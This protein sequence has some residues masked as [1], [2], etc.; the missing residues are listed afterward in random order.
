M[1]EGWFSAADLAVGARGKHVMAKAAVGVCAV[2]RH[3]DSSRP[4]EFDRDL[5]LLQALGVYVC[6]VADYCSR[7]IEAAHIHRY[8]AVP[9]RVRIDQVERNTQLVVAKCENLDLVRH[10]AVLSAKVH[11]VRPVDL[12]GRHTVSRRLGRRRDGNIHQTDEG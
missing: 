5:T 8:L 9:E 4:H 7:C 12:S 2:L 1:F 3:F 11:L 6:D 10:L